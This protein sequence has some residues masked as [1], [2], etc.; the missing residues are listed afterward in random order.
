MK[1]NMELCR[2]ILFAIEEQYVDAVIVNLKIDGYRDEEIA[3]NCSLLSDAGLIKSYKSQNADN[4]LYV[5]YVGAL[6]WEGHNFIDNIREDTIW[7]N[8]KK[9]IK[10][11]ALPMTLEVIREISSA[12]VAAMA[13]AAGGSL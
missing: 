12:L 2:K 13:K 6:T 9:K 3:Y 7:N 4:H 8:T 10:E 1:R 5:Y 11:K